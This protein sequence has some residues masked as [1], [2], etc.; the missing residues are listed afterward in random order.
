M[1]KGVTNIKHINVKPPAQI[2]VNKQVFRKKKSYR[3]EEQPNMRWLDMQRAWRKNEVSADY[4]A[5]REGDELRWMNE[6]D[7][8]FRERE[9]PEPKTGQGIVWEQ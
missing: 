2:L 8:N 6:V 1:P 3:V 5:D 7:E 9:R 4:A